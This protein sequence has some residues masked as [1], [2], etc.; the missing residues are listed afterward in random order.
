MRCEALGKFGQQ[1]GKTRLVFSVV[2]RPAS[3]GQDG[4]RELSEEAIALAQ[5]RDHCN[6]D[7]SGS[8]GDSDERLA[9]HNSFMTLLI[10]LF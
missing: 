9:S 2:W 6:L 4:H 7:L 3:R 8:K 5:G 10:F 1:S